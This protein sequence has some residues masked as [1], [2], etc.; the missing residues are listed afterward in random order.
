MLKIARACR[1]HKPT[2]ETASAAA[3]LAI[4]WLALPALLAGG[5]G[6]RD[7]PDR[8][9]AVQPAGGTVAGLPATDCAVRVDRTAFT[10]YRNLVARLMRGER[11]PQE[12]FDRVW[13]MPA[14]TALFDATSPRLVNTHILTNVTRYVHGGATAATATHDAPDG[15]KSRAGAVPKRKDLV[16]ALTWAR[17]NGTA[18]DSLVNAVSTSPLTCGVLPKIAGYLRP[19][20]L[21]DTLRVLFL[22]AGPDLRWT[23]SEVLVDA[24]V[25]AA[26]GPTRLPNLLAAQLYR[27]LAPRD[28]PEPYKARNGAAALVATFAQLRRDG[29]AGWLEDFPEVEFDPTHPLVGRSDKERRSWHSLATRSLSALQEMLPALLD[30]PAVL[31]TKGTVIDDLLRGNRS[32]SATGYAMAALIATRL[33]EP[34][35]QAAARGTPGDFLAAYQEAATKGDVPALAERAWI[36][37]EKLSDLPPFPAPIYRS[38]MAMLAPPTGI[39][40]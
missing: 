7:A 4:L 9:P 40:R 34:R 8:T 29:V 14:Y 25:A 30:D 22:V 24:G 21:P 10:A 26:A 16:D 19:G 35:L 18:L 37:P 28:G 2:A 23:G 38:L 17:D 12:A 20:L 11:V 1:A 39:A 5:C 27:A 3:R 33:G 15:R 13:A 6:R 31:D 36:A 32:Y